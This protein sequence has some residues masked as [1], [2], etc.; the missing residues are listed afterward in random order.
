MKPKLKVEMLP[1]DVPQLTIDDIL[2]F[3][4]IL[5]KLLQIFL[6]Y[7]KA[8]RIGLQIFDVGLKFTH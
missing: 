6:V 7:H 5:L 4:N 3:D 2:S 8:P 1:V